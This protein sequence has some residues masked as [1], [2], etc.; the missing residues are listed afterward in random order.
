LRTLRVC[1]VTETFHPVIGGGET[2]A[3]AVAVGLG[4]H[5]IATRVITRRSD[6]AFAPTETIDGVPVQRLGPAGP[7]HLKKWAMLP[8]LL[9]ALLRQRRDW[10]VVLVSGY[11]VLGIAAVVAA[12]HLGKCV[13]LKAD[14]DGEMSGSYF[15]GGAAK[16]GLA[17]QGRLVAG[18]VALRNQLLRRA[19]AFVSLSGGMRAELEANGVRPERIIDIPNSVDTARFRPVEPAERAALRVRMGLPAAGPVVIFAGR[20]LASKGVM[21]LARSWA[22]L[23]PAF[24]EATLVVVGSGKGLMHDC[25]AVFNAFIDARGLRPRVVTTGFVTNVEA[26]LQ[27]ADIFA[28]PT[29]DEA[30]GL[31]LVE[32]MATGLAAVASS[33]GGIKDIVEPGVN[34]LSIEPGD[35][36]ALAAA[37]RRLLTDP[38]LRRRLGE[39]AMATVEARY[40]NAAVL[41]RYVTL[42]HG[43]T[44]QHPLARPADVQPGVDGDRA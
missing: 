16:L 3:R 32:A 25:E 8:G 18:F 27:A 9:V 13:V 6:A 30:F 22:E 44:R 2:Q 29:T 35:Q 24:P 26:Y 17:G 31:A 41:E 14:N 37:L 38:A 43:L 7:G 33:V 39:A 21:D 10:D 1:L 20:L 23:A 28:F 5:G 11:R 42:L 36:P 34:A 12:R 19:D 4:A 15:R 40:T